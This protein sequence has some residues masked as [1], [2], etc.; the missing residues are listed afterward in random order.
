MF[1]AKWLWSWGWSAAQAPTSTRLFVFDIKKK[2]KGSL[3]NKLVCTYLEQ[4]WSNCAVGSPG[5]QS[6]HLTTADQHTNTNVVGTVTL[7]WLGLKSSANLC[8][9]K[10][11]Q[12]GNVQHSEHV[13]F[14]SWSVEAVSTNAAFLSYYSSVTCSS[15]LL[16]LA[17]WVGCAEADLEWFPLCKVDH[18]GM[19][20]CFWGLICVLCVLLQ[21]CNA[22]SAIKLQEGDDLN[23][24]ARTR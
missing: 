18:R 8:S 12:V 14:R 21:S 1:C 9:K 13:S 10:K 4:G 2:T 11:Q 23:V 24:P 5:S 16:V 3:C 20:W 22:I 7:H 17:E 6:L 15:S 19:S